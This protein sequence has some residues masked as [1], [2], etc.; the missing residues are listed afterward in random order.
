MEGSQ[1]QSGWPNG[2]I[3]FSRSN[4]ATLRALRVC[5]QARRQLDQRS[6]T[7]GLPISNRQIQ[8]ITATKKRRLESTDLLAT[9]TDETQIKSLR[10]PYNIC[11]NLCFICGRHRQNVEDD[12]GICFQSRQTAQVPGR[13]TSGF[14]FIR[15][16]DD[17]QTGGE[18]YQNH[19][20]SRL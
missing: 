8:A 2:G 11:A 9:K 15:A 16:I 14:A 6:R 12:S 7:A 5:R 20:Q 10:N 3:E 13:S 17:L 19:R 18:C 4:E 1:S